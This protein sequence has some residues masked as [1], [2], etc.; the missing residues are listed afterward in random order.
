MTL[1][2]GVDRADRGD[3]RG[4]DKKKLRR[5]KSGRCPFRAVELSPDVNHAPGVVS[6]S[7]S[8]R[9]ADSL[10]FAAIRCALWVRLSVIRVKMTAV[11]RVLFPV[12]TNNF[13]AASS[14]VRHRE[15]RVHIGVISPTHSGAG[16][17]LHG[18]PGE[19]RSNSPAPSTLHMRP[20]QRPPAKL[21]LLHCHGAFDKMCRTSA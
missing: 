14:A 5:I 20:L 12:N 6:G 21:F 9:N 19:P 15:N 3:E 10:H 4:W 13:C 11:R 16:E 17:R 7:T 18:G 8:R 1:D 2:R